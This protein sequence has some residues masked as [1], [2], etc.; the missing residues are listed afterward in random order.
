[1]SVR[2]KPSFG[3]F[4]S[5][6]CE[7]IDSG[8]ELNRNLQRATHGCGTYV[9]SSIAAEIRP[10]RLADEPPRIIINGAMRAADGHLGRVAATI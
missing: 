5:H 4:W 9:D 8:D 6:G 3:V 10:G 1:M 2:P 7:L